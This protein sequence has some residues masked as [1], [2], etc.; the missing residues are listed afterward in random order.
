MHSLLVRQGNQNGTNYFPI[1]LNSLFF[2]K[3]S[4]WPE[5]KSREITDSPNVREIF[6]RSSTIIWKAVCEEALDI[7]QDTFGLLCSRKARERGFVLPSSLAY[8][9]EYYFTGTAG[10]SALHVLPC[11]CPTLKEQIY[12]LATKTRRLQA[13]ISEGSVKLRKEI[14]KGTT[15]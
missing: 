2:P 12:Y 15:A 1:N 8:R 13:F 4:S 14:R 3:C 10:R 7:V 5:S 9:P 11:C 6:K